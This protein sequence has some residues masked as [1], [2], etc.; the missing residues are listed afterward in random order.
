CHRDGFYQSKGKHIRHLKLKITNKIDGYCPSKIDATV[1]NTTREVHVLFLRTHVGHTM[2]L[3]KIPL[4]KS[5]RKLLASKISQKVPFDEIINTV[6]DNFDHSNYGRIHLLT[7]KDLFN[8][9]QLYNLNKESV[10]HANDCISVESWVIQSREQGTYSI[11]KYFKRQGDLDGDYRELLENDF[12]LVIMNDGQLEALKKYGSDCLCIDGTHGLNAYN[13]QLTTLMV[14]DD[15]RQGFPCMFAFSNRS[16]TYVMTVIFNVTKKLFCKEI[17][18]KIFMSDMDETFYKAWCEVMGAVDVRLFC[19]WHVIKAWKKNLNTKIR[20]T[21]KQKSTYKILRML[22]EESDKNAQ[23]SEV[24]ISKGT[25]ITILIVGKITKKL[26]ELRKRHKEVDSTTN[27]TV[28]L[29]VEDGKVWTV[30]SSTGLDFYSIEILNKSCNCN[31]RCDECNACIH[32]YICS[33][34]NSAIR[35]NM[36]KHVHL[37]CT[38]LQ[39]LN[40]PAAY[41]TIGDTNALVVDEQYENHRSAEEIVLKQL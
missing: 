8:I 2:D 40:L 22:F 28:I 6:R 26:S 25:D 12:L 20:D 16:D 7:R 36:C 30:S 32:A 17:S 33:C 11:V 1:I 13:F 21:E 37:L 10:R 27:S 14:L 29:E 15:L 23:D 35:W 19:V 18:P 31:L 24:H 5:D 38:H 39:K 34:P 3:G 41:E 9:E 4:K